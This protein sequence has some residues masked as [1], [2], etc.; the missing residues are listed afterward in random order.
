MGSAVIL[1]S[2]AASLELLSGSE[3]QFQKGAHVSVDRIML[4]WV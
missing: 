3:F 4:V 1:R 2:S